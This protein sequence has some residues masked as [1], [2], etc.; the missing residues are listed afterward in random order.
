MTG[1]FLHP[2]L[3]EAVCLNDLTLF[4]LATLFYPF[5]PFF[6]NINPY[7]SIYLLKQITQ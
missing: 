4:S 7:T 3:V 2:I 6:K 5:L 1:Q